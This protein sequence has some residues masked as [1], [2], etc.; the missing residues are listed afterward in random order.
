MPA[1]ATIVFISVLA[2]FS[3]LNLSFWLLFISDGVSN[4]KRTHKT[5]NDGTSPLG[6]IVSFMNMIAII[7]TI[8]SFK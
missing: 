6:H 7:S 4:L 2:K 1:S 5:D 3:S 8:L